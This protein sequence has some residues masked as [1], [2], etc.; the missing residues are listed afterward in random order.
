MYVECDVCQGIGEICGICDQPEHDCTCEEPDYTTCLECN[1]TGERNNEMVCSYCDGDL[2]PHCH[3][4][5]EDDL[6]EDEE[7][8][9]EEDAVHD[10]GE[11]KIR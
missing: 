11:L 4:E 8:E 10:E 3:G 5:D 2:C 6:E 9:E 7:D 1:G